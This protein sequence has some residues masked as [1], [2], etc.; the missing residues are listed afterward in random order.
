MSKHHILIFDSGVGGLSIV[1]HIRST[2]GPCRITYLADNALFPYGLLA[3]QQLL[4]RVTGLI[5]DV[6]ASYQPEL[7]VI[8]CNSAS[9]LVLP[10]LRQMLDIPIVGVVP[11]IKPAAQSSAT[12]VVGLL[13][14]PGTIDREYTDDLI[15]DYANHCEIIRVGSA[16]LV[17]AVEQKMRGGAAHPDAATAVIKQ[18]R[19]HP[20]WPELDTIVLACTHFPLAID[21]LSAAAPEIKHWVDSGAAIARRVKS[22]LDSHD[23][24]SSEDKASDIAL[25]TDLSS[26]TEALQQSFKAYGFK[27]FALWRA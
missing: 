6:A 1:Q 16:E 7:I 5:G 20:R 26:H 27:E 15:R 24:P 21:E 12:H 10:T 23:H 22:L 9:T 19:Q 4:D 17:A 13:A 8:G 3:E 18:F 2:V 11:A 25:F 14:T